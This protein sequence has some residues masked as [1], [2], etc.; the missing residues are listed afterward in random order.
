VTV[1]SGTDKRKRVNFIPEKTQKPWNVQGGRSICIFQGFCLFAP[2]P[3]KAHP[4]CRPSSPVAVRVSGFCCMP[5]LSRALQ[6]GAQGR[7]PGSAVASSPAVQ[8]RRRRQ[9]KVRPTRSI[10][11]PPP[12]RSPSP[13]AVTGLAACR[14]SLRLLPTPRLCY[15]PEDRGFGHGR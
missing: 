2:R 8:N 13:G 7:A 11:S 12:D 6:G 14:P 1:F 15:D 9:K 4:F 3:Q 10:L 5:R